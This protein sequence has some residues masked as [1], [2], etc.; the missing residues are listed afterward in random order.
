[1]PKNKLFLNITN[2]DIY[3]SIQELHDKID[4]VKICTIS[5]DTK[6]QLHNARITRVENYGK[7]FIGAVSSAFV[8]VF[9]FIINNFKW[10][11][12]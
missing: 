6:L 12:W 4:N 2:K 7:I 5:N 3:K 11:T 8:G 10:K 9:L 1:L